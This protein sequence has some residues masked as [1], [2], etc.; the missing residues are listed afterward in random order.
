[1]PTMALF[2]GWIFDA[3]TAFGAGTIMGNDLAGRVTQNAMY[4]VIL[5]GA[6]W[7]FNGS[8]FMLWL[9]F[10]ELQAKSAR[11][12]LYIGMLEKEM[13]WYDNRKAGINALIPRTQT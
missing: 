8:Y 4:L 13:A 12:A 3:F 5:G 9:V 11:D 1:M 2:L 7:F 10:G 6:S